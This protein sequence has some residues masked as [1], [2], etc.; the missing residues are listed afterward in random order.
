MSPVVSSIPVWRQL[1][2]SIDTETLFS[3]FAHQPWAVLLDS[4]DA[5]HAD[6]CYDIICAAPMATLTHINGI[7]KL[8]ITKGQ[9]V[10][11]NN[12]D[13][14][15]LINSLLRRWFPESAPCP[16]P[17]SGGV[18]GAFGYDLG[19]CTES[20]PTIANADIQLPDLNLG[21]YE[22]ALIRKQASNHWLLVHARG[23]E[24]LERTLASLEAQ[25]QTPPP[26][27]SPFKLSSAWR[28]QI[29][30]QDYLSRFAQIQEYL[31]SG[32][33]YQVNLTQRFECC[34]RGDEWQAYCQLSRA[35][36]APFSA[37]MRLPDQAIL[38]ISPERFIKLEEGQIES[39]PIKGTLPRH[40][41]PQLDADAADTL[42]NSPKDRAENLMIVDLLRNDIGKVAAPGSVH[43]PKLFEVESFPAVHHLVST[44]RA[45]L[46]TG[47][48]ATDL[49]RAAF[50]G[51]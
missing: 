4:A 5:A 47:A 42:A 31:H 23:T 45:T 50:P 28:Q 33:C 7:N 35:N 18:L 51:G 37:F 11:S 10:E 3:Y 12:E 14:F 22:W 44:V 46:D 13:P 48:K 30:K 32:D 36:R 43:V 16:L 21:F 1:D 17:F 26:T 40:R 27:K 2:W 41:D 9:L 25:L 24:A 29:S 15:K 19:R 49:L 8:E 20:L 38:S 34:Y 39:K 6:A